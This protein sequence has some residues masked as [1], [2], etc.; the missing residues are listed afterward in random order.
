MST[1]L[2][3]ADG[4]WQA[5]RITRLDAD[6]PDPGEGLRLAPV[7]AEALQPPNGTVALLP[8]N[9]PVRPHA[10]ALKA[11]P[12]IA[13]AFDTVAEGRP[14]SQARQLRDAGYTGRLIA[15][16]VGVTLDRL[17]PMR[18]MGIDAFV[19]PDEAAARAALQ[20]FDYADQ[21]LPDADPAR[22]Y[23][24]LARTGCI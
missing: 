22:G 2:L 21:P 9:L 24:P 6:T 16:G 7:S 13:L 19:L 14:Y 15:T 4:Q 18:A 11:L 8:V 23:R 3:N 5:T 17:V 1:V 20:R 12:A 10:E